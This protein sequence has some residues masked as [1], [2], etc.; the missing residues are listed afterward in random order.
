MC[1]YFVAAVPG[2]EALNKAALVDS[3]EYC[4]LKLISDLFRGICFSR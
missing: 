4:G 3:C 1:Y 2:A